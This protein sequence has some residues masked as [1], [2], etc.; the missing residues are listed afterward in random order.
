MKSKNNYSRV[1]W[2]A[3]KSL[4]N[5]RKLRCYNCFELKPLKINSTISWINSNNLKFTS[6]TNT[7]MQIEF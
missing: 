3:R 1:D 4:P 6:Q 7:E 5:V 2:K